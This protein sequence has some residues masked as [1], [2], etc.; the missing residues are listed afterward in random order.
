LIELQREA[1][2]L[3]RDQA[4]LGELL[5]FLNRL[6]MSL[7]ALTGF[8]MDDMTRDDGWLFLMLGR[9]IE[10]LQFLSESLAVFLRGSAVRDQAALEWLLELGNSI[11]TYRTRYL[12][13]PQLIAVLDLLLLDAQ[14]PHSLAFQLRV[15][16][17]SLA[18]LDQRFAESHENPLRELGERLQGFDLGSLDE[19]ALFGSAGVR[20]VLAGLADLL[21]A[22]AAGAAEVSD[23]LALRHFVHVDAVSQQTLSS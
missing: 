23:R 19:K 2:M 7:A 14:N 18:Q 6:L 15:L 17:D 4:D 9:R 21:Q 12:A 20:E 22:I 1:Q 13:A 16:D 8:A 5:D 10:R 3:E 11:I